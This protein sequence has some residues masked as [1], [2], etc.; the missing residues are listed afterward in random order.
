MDGTN[1]EAIMALGRALGLT[2]DS[3]RSPVRLSRIEME[4]VLRYVAE[5]V[6]VLWEHAALIEFASCLLDRRGLPSTTED[7]ATLLGEAAAFAAPPRREHSPPR[8]R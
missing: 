8:E 6:P 1:G 5:A 7:V 2:A 3:E 4:Q